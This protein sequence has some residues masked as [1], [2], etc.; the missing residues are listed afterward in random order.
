MNTLLMAMLAACLGC[1][2]A[3][4]PGAAAPAPE[5]AAVDTFP[6]FAW[7][8]DAAAILSEEDE[9]RLEARLRA[10]EARTRHQMVV[11]TVPSLSGRDVADFARDLGNRW[12]VGRA[13]H[14]DGVI[15]LVA[16]N[17]RKARIAVGSGHAR[18]LPDAAADD[19]VAREMLPR[20]R[21]GDF[22]GGIEAAAAAL[23]RQIEGPR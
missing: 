18:V 14:D 20:F 9:Q 13:G 7:V 12:G 4:E 2:A 16:P 10:F 3:A 19:I 15:I 22:A 11:V 5:A 1:P 23:M 6:A 17:E 8:A 21:D